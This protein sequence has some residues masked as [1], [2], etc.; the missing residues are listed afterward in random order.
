MISETQAWQL[1]RAFA[2]AV[3][4]AA[5]KDVLAVAV[6]GSLAAGSYRP[7]RSDIDTFIL[8][9]DHS[10]P[11]AVATIRGVRDEF[12]QT[13]DIPKGL[14]AVIVRQQALWP[15]YDP[16][17]ELVP[18]I[19]RL[20]QQ[21]VLIWGQLDVDAIPEPDP[22]DIEAYITV[23]YRWLHTHY[24]ACRPAEART[25]DATVNTILYELRALLWQA[26]GRYVLDKGAVVAR[27]QALLDDP[28]LHP[29]LIRLQDY[30]AGE[31]DQPLSFWEDSL[32]MI[33]Q[34]VYT[35]LPA[36]KP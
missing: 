11:E 2:Q 1:A 12:Q 33:V 18:E 27:A 20:K 31:E 29:V 6:I 17:Q 26:E 30:L 4:V 28:A 7:G 10:S 14:G 23:F 35:Q 25:V 9:H 24:A 15:P 32:Q 5:P 3:A 13:Y 34:R 19:L 22:A 16:G 8:I 36:L 21:G